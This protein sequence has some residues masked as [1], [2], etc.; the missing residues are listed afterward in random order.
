MVEL[1]KNA[2]CVVQTAI[3]SASNGYNSYSWSTS[4]TGTPVISTSQTYTATSTGSITLALLLQLDVLLSK[5]KSIPFGNTITN[6]VT[7]P[8]ADQIVTCPN[9]GKDLPNIFF[10]GQLQ[11]D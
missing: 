6:P 11:S 8:T 3:L 7:R 5:K 2:C 1:Y 10:V 4:P 9:N